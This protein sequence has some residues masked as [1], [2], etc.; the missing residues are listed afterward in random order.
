MPRDD[1][2][3]WDFCLSVYA[4]PGVSAACLDLQERFGVNVSLLLAA[5]F[6]GSR[7]TELTAKEVEDLAAAAR[8]WHDEIVVSLRALRTRLKQGP[9]PAPGEKTDGLR[10]GIK[11]LELEAEKIELGL[12]E[13][14]GSALPARAPVSADQAVRSNLS[15]VL[16][17]FGGNRDDETS[18]RSLDQIAD[19]VV[20]V[21]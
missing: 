13:E 10:N 12:L 18:R 5:A 17:L 11:G 4:K 3:L 19:A 2:S 16:H 1:A 9:N 6:L 21:M 15:E 7:R 20:G 8:A 14:L